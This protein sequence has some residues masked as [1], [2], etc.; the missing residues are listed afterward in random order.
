MRV[1]EGDMVRHLVATKARVVVRKLRGV[2][3]NAEVSHSYL[4]A[5]LTGDR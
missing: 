5:G 3:S 2:V 4:T 1:N